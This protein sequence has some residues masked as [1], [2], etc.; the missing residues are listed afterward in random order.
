VLR[1]AVSR[2]FP[3]ANGALSASAACLFTNTPDE[4]FIID[5]A[6]EA[7]EVL[8]VSPC[9]GHGFKF[10]SVIGEIVADLVETGATSHDID[11]FRLDRFRGAVT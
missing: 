10:A 1:D 9:S 2:Y 11:L 7:P 3:A 6:P 5:R 4:H 8:L